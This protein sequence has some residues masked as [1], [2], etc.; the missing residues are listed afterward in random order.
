MTN[1]PAP[2]PA[3]ALAGAGSPPT[4]WL[5]VAEDPRYEVSDAGQVRGPSGRILRGNPNKAE[6]GY[7]SVQLGS[8]RRRYIHRLVAIAFLGLPDGHEPDHLNRIKTDN[9]AA[10]LEVVTHAENL[11][12]YSDARTHCKQG[13]EL[14]PDN[15]IKRG[16][17]RRGC[18]T[19]VRAWDRAKLERR[20]PR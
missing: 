7:L 4:Q 5:P 11:R 8:R 9:R 10:N 19:C 12:R 1:P 16:L 20:K 3:P 17:T 2:A 6:D 18:R 14:T 15:T 13:H